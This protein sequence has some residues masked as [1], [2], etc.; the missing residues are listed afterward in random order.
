[1]KTKKLLAAALAAVVVQT[2]TTL[3]AEEVQPQ[4]THQQ[5]IEVLK[6]YVPLL[7]SSSVLRHITQQTPVNS[8]D[9]SLSRGTVVMLRSE[10]AVNVVTPDARFNELLL[11]GKVDLRSR[12]GETRCPAV[13]TL[14]T[15][16]KVTEAGNTTTVTTTVDFKFNS[17]R[18]LNKE[19]VD[20]LHITGTGELKVERK[21]D[22]TIVT[23]SSE[24]ISANATFQA[25]GEIPFRRY[26]DKTTEVTT[27]GLLNR[28]DGRTWY[29]TLPF[30]EVEVLFVTNEKNGRVERLAYIN[31]EVHSQ[32]QITNLFQEARR[33]LG[34]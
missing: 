10:C 20:S 1:M 4:L 26:I 6:L 12:T 34:L 13:F 14:E 33:Q 24:D 30:G 21:P 29:F 25:I 27:A 18:Q 16:P 3:K 32:A 31:Q 2:T 19:M 22:G 15:N 5:K 23:T 8:I 9:G 28:Y 17:L 7:T 11:I